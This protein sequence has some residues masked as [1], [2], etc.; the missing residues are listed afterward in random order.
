MRLEDFQLVDIDATDNSIIK[1]DFLNVYH[2]QAANLSDS[3]QG[4]EFILGES[5]NNHQIG[6]AYLQ[7]EMTKKRR[8]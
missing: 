3:D 2:Q 4:N 5:N 6:N 7:Y 8:C 1:R